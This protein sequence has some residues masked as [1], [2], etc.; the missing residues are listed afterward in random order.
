MSPSHEDEKIRTVRGVS[1]HGFSFAIIIYESLTFVFMR[2]EPYTLDSYIHAVKRGARGLPITRNTSDKWR[3]VRL[4]Y[5]LNDEYRDDAWERETA[6]LGM[7]GRPAHWPE[8]TPLIKILAWTLM[9]NHFHILFKEI[10]EGG[11]SKFMQRLCGSMTVH[12]N[13][14]YEEKGSIFQGS[15]R[16]KTVDK[17]SHL[18]YLPAYIMVKNVFELYPG[19]YKK[20]AM[21][22]DTAWDWAV[23]TYP[24]SS[25]ADFIEN[26]ESHIIEKDILGSLFETPAAF[27]KNAQD[28]ILG[29]LNYESQTFV[30]NAL[31]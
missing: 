9:P 4:L 2:I 6:N 30:E 21:E 28:M 18:L 26:R 14:K 7:F 3:F 5:Y 19:G 12:F 13:L 29:R 1:S 20:A 22:F 31:E 17:N 23:H 11:M 25:L 27:R 8:R 10:K 16:A 24:F 15:Y